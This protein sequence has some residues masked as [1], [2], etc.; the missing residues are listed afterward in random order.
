MHDKAYSVL[1]VAPIVFSSKFSLYLRSI[2]SVS[3]KSTAIMRMNP[4]R[5]NESCQI[6]TK[7]TIILARKV[8]KMNKKIAIFSFI[9]SAKVSESDIN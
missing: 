9:A 2:S 4:I 8:L 6:T 7:E 3:T 5:T 1:A